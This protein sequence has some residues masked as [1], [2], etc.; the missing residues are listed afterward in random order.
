MI[1]PNL[2]IVGAPKCGTTSLYHYLKQHE[3]VF[4][5]EHKEP[6]YFLRDIGIERIPEG[7][8]DESAYFSLFENGKDHKY[9]GEASVLYLGYPEYSIPAIQ[10][11]LGDDVHI[12]IMLRNP[13]DRCYSAYQHVKRYN[14]LERLSFADALAKDEQRLEDDKRMTPAAR[15]K[16]LGMYHDMVKAYQ[17]SF[18]KVHVIIYEDFIQDVDNGL[19]GVF[20]FLQIP[21]Q[22]LDFS[23]RHMV[24]GWEWKSNAM[25]DLTVQ[26]N[27]FKNVL[28]AVLPKSI[29]KSIRKKVI[30]MS[31]QEV[32]LIPTKEQEE[33]KAYYKEEVA[34]VEA[35]LNRKLPWR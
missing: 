14:P 21:Y 11:D 15:Y 33:L 3:D 17:E 2:L 16:H 25:K 23:A 27:P 12:I 20:D 28:K 4:M 18:S 13:V 1:K 19:K 35:L 22:A 30:D 6:H 5:S 31:T 9:R 34:R 29:R 10:K 24:G 8:G 7:L 26:D 32:P